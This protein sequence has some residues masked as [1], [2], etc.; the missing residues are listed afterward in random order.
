[1]KMHSA[2]RLGFLSFLTLLPSA[3]VWILLFFAFIAKNN[4]VSFSVKYITAAQFHAV[5][6]N[7]D[8]MAFEHLNENLIALDIYVLEP[9]KLC[10]SFQP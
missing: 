1:M 9:L 6:S 4:N 8:T 10:F 3:A 7:L 5:T 2:L